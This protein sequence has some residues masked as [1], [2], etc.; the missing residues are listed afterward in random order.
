[1]PLCASALCCLL[2]HAI[3]PAYKSQVCPAA[4]T[5]SEFIPVVALPSGM[6]LLPCSLQISTWLEHISDVVLIAWITWKALADNWYFVSFRKIVNS[7]LAKAI[8][9]TRVWQ[10]D[11]LNEVQV[12]KSQMPL[13]RVI[14]SK[15]LLNSRL[16]VSIWPSFGSVG[17]E[18]RD[19]VVR[20]W[21]FWSHIH[22]MF[23]SW[24]AALWRQ[25]NIL[26]K[27]W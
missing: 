4:F 7:Y 24:K 2:F 12:Q 26:F 9:T 22:K 17:W 23:F 21:E 8:R 10:E 14:F 3:S 15:E 13:E 1:M 25:S 6:V 19:G 5:K 18:Q 11:S 27:Y 20:W 16:Y